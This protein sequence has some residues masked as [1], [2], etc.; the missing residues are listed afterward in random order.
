MSNFPKSQSLNICNLEV[1]SSFRDTWVEM[2]QHNYWLCGRIAQDPKGIRCCIGNH[3]QVDKVISLS[4]D[5]DYRK[6]DRTCRSICKRNL[7][8]TCDIKVH[9]FWSRPK[10]HLTPMEASPGGTWDL[11][12]LVQCTIPKQMVSLSARYRFWKIFFVLVWWIGV[13]PVLASCS[14]LV[15]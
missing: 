6:G 3:R 9:C 11:S 8:T 2:G 14:V 4:H 1:P 7:L 15:Q 12:S 13:G 10:V 5:Q